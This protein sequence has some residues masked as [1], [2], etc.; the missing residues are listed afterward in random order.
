MLD[1]SKLSLIIFLLLVN[2]LVSA[3]GCRGSIKLIVLVIDEAECV[4]LGVGIFWNGASS[5][6]C[7]GTESDGDMIGLKYS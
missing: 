6:C 4:E 3:N 7:A 2:A 1:H 5:T